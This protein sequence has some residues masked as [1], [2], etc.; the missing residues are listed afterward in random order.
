MIISTLWGPKEIPSK[1]CM[2]CGEEKPLSEF[3]VRSYG[4]QGNAREIRNDCKKCQM[5]QS[6]VVN[7]LKKIYAHLK[8]SMDDQCPICLRTER[9]ILSETGREKTIWVCEHD[10]A[11][12]E[13]R[14]W[15]CDYCNTVIARAKE[16]TGTL[17]RAIKYLKGEL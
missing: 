17:E 2:K 8:P 5:K 11:T 16:S 6:K 7:E 1:K 10:H 12:G 15:I 9:E 3:G 13:F 4:K 14:G